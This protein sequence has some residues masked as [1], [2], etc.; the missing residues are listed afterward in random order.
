MTTI[1]DEHR[2]AARDWIKSRPVFIR[3]GIKL[4]D[5]VQTNESDLAAFRAQACAE[6]REKD[7]RIAEEFW[8]KSDDPTDEPDCTVRTDASLSIGAAIRAQA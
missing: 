3:N 1:T 7:A 2:D 5:A 8:P 6:Q 4:D